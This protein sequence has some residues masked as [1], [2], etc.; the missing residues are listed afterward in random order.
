[1]KFEVYCD[2]ALPDLFTSGKPQGQYLMIGALW[3]PASLREDVK[4]KIDTLRERHAVFGEMKW[5]KISPSRVTFYEDVVDLFFAYGSNMRFRCIAVDREN[6]NLAKFHNNDGE[7]GFYKFYYQL[8]HHWILDHNEYQFFCDLK[9]SRSPT[10]MA[11]LRR[12]LSKA[13][14]SAEISNVQSLPST[15]LALMQLCDIL[16][17]A[18][19]SRLNVGAPASPAKLAIVERMEASL[20]RR[21]T[22]TWKSEDK[23]NVFKINLQGRQ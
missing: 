5:R 9:T 10:R 17:G 14:I 11:E 18:A 7:L 22:P 3:L 4:S 8:L 6:I 16:L 13:N 15:Q 19:N 23:F 1:M 20:G 2:E 21:I 12:V